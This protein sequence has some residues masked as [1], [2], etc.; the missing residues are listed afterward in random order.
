MLAGQ[1]LYKKRALISSAGTGTDVSSS[2]RSSFDPRFCPLVSLFRGPI[3]LP[4]F[5][6]IH[7][8]CT[9]LSNGAVQRVRLLIKSNEQRWFCM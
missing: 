1:H 6:G 5:N 4:E 8:T 9:M 2:C 3:T 7:G